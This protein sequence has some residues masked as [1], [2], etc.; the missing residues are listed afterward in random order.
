MEQIM[1]LLQRIGEIAIPVLQQLA[2]KRDQAG[3]SEAKRID[4]DGFV[5]I[6][7][8]QSIVS[9]TVSDPEQWIAEISHFIDGLSQA[10]QR[11]LTQAAAF[12]A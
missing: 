12:V 6:T 4:T 9:G 3:A 8:A 10:V 2:G 7:P 5:H 1:P 11:E